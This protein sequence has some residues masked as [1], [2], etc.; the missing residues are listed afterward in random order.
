MDGGDT[1]SVAR[2]YDQYMGWWSRSV[3]AHF[4]DWLG[5]PDRL[6]WLDIGCGTGALTEAVLGRC[7]PRLLV[8]CDR[9]QAFVRAA[10]ARLAAPVTRFEVADALAVPFADSTFDA[11]VS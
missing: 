6:R 8:G 10:A 4:V 9:S 7:D 2:P 5:L 11:V 1:W 3:A